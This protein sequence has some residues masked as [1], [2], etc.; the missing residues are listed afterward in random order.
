MTKRILSIDGGGICGI[1]PLALLTEIEAQRGRCADL[2]DMI[3]GTS[4]GGIIATGLAHRVPAKTIRGMLTD[5]GGTIF[6]NP[7][8]GLLGPK[9]EAAPLEEFLNQTFGGAM[10][11]G[12]TK[13]ELIV[14]TVDLI[15]RHRCSSNLGGPQKILTIS[16]SRTWRGQRARLK[17][18]SSPRIS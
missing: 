18:I 4:I 10:L 9:Y 11:N 13:P 6:T 12:V 1:L 8:L 15:D 5:D 7:T 16:R 2:F 14:P 3:A 17:P